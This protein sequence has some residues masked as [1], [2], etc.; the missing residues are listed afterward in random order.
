MLT[1]GGDAVVVCACPADC[2]GCVCVQVDLECWLVVVTRWW[3]VRVLLTALAACV[4]RLTSSA[5]WWW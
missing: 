2:V 4:C 5:G 3:Y 1:G